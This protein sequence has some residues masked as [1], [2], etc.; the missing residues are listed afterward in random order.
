MKLLLIL[1]IS[2]IGTSA[3]AQTQPYFPE[4]ITYAFT[5][6][7]KVGQVQNYTFQNQSPLPDHTY[8]ITCYPKDSAHEVQHQQQ[9]Q[10]CWQTPNTQA[11]G[12][13]NR[14]TYLDLKVGHSIGILEQVFT[15]E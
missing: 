8:M 15:C 2:L 1:P 12:C 10:D 5:N 14:F 6:H 9:Q 11:S 3:L 7:L 4:A 13:V